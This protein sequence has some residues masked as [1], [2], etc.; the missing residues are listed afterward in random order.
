MVS[1]RILWFGGFNK[2]KNKVNDF[3]FIEILDDANNLE[4]IFVHRNSIPSSLLPEIE[5]QRKEGVYVEFEIAIDKNG[6]KSAINIQ[7]QK[8]VGLIDWFKNGRGYIKRDNGCDVRVESTLHLTSDDIVLFGLRYNAY[9]QRDESIRIQKVDQFETDPEI[10]SQCA[11]SSIPEIFKFFLIPYIKTL[12][13]KDAANFV[14]KQIK[15]LSYEEQ[16]NLIQKIANQ[17]EEILIESAELRDMLPFNNTRFYTYLD[18]VNKW[19]ERGSEEVKNIL[20]KELIFKM[21]NTDKIERQVYW[22]NVPYL[23]NNLEYQGILWNFA[24]VEYQIEFIVNNFRSEILNKNSVSML[25]HKINCLDDIKRS[26]IIRYILERAEPILLESSKLRSLLPLGSYS[27]FVNKHLQLDRQ[28]SKHSRLLE[29]LLEKIKQANESERSV[30]WSK[31]EYL[32]NNVQYK[33]YL[34]NLAP[35]Q[36]QKSYLGSRYNNF[37]KI[38]DEFYKSD[39]PYKNSLV[40]SWLTLYQLDE[41]EIQLIES[42]DNSNSG[43]ARAQMISARG[44]EKLV[45][46]FYKDL[47]YGVEDISIHQVTS[48]SNIW[49]QGDIRINSQTLI[50]VKN[51]RQSVNSEVYSEFCIPSFKQNRNRDVKIV[52]VLSP[53]LQ[54]EYMTGNSQPKFSVPN[55]QI[56][57]EFDRSQLTK[58]ENLFS[59]R[60]I[61][62]NMSRG[63]DPKTFLPPW[64]FDYDD[65]FYIEQI[66]A[67]N[68]FK[69][70]ADTEIPSWEDLVILNL[71]PLPLLIASKRQLPSNW[72]YNLAEW[73]VEFIEA[74]VNLPIRRITLPYVFLTLLKHTLK[75][76]SCHQPDYNPQ[77]YSEILFPKIMQSS[78]DQFVSQTPLK[79]FDPMNIIRDFCATLQSLWDYR[80]QSDLQEFKIFQFNGRGLLTGK[81]HS[82]E[83][84]PTTILAYCGGW[85]DKKG[86]CGY[87]P[88]VIGKHQNC[89]VCGRLIC[90]KDDC[91]FCSRGCEAYLERKKDLSD[92]NFF[93]RY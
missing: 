34:W 19:L 71:N 32:K 58:L 7:P 89:P 46:K 51:A 40:E 25:V 79:I 93:H 37:V 78:R 67:I 90:P 13:T 75:M 68:K 65:R 60:F 4:N 26:R 92:R 35:I 66:T 59:D 29:E 81:R 70:L 63:D 69:K 1:G 33:G 44:A 82:Q 5:G 12:G 39:Y 36:F 23:R 77:L 49:I 45:M 56:L 43:F 11:N 41:E 87:S 22:D 30:Y 24:P 31:V 91:R 20:R 9:Y 27:D 17:S 88:L 28:S 15:A 53:Y 3:G 21:Q 74:L 76:L 10:I 48:Q 84:S 18:L 16:N 61:K 50:D 62:I 57:G 42:W 64:L 52:G 6:K 38:L 55:P 80:K 2:K 86:K 85:V 83:Y 14:S 47:S 54:E 73:K 72:K 8:Y